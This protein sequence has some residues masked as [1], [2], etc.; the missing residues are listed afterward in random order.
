MT[1]KDPIAAQPHQLSRAEAE[2]IT[3][4]YDAFYRSA[5]QDMTIVHQ[6]R[7]THRRIVE[8]TESE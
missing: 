2:E 6:M 5:E 8:R 1:L 7:A 4:S 3:Q